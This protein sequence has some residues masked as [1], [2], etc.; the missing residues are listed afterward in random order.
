MVFFALC[1]KN[2]LIGV[3]KNKW[4]NIINGVRIS[5]STLAKLSKNEYVS[6]DTLVRI[7]N[8]LFRI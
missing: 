6:M 4:Y 7:C 1:C 5:S 2:E 8:Q 3:C